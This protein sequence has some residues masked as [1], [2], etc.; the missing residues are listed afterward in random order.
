[1]R[2]MRRK[3][4][5]V[6]VRIAFVDALYRQFKKNGDKFRTEERRWA[7]RHLKNTKTKDL[8][9]TAIYIS[10]QY[11]NINKDGVQ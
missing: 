10:K 4:D 3:V 1:M 5:N 11:T 8:I 2:K 7:F 6:T 9:P